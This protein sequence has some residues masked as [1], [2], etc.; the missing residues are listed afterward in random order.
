MGHRKSTGSC[1]CLTIAALAAF[2]FSLP[3]G[4]VPRLNWADLDAPE[5]RVY[6]SE[7]EAKYPINAFFFEREKWEGHAS[8]HV[9]WFIRGTDYPRYESSTVFPF[10][11][12]L[13]SKVD[14][15]ERSVYFPFF[16]Q[17]TDGGE[18]TTL[19]PLTLFAEDQNSWWNFYGWLFVRY[20]SPDNSSRGTALFPFFFHDVTP[21]RTA[22]TI[23]ALM[24]YEQRPESSTLI[25]PVFYSNAGRDETFTISPA[26]IYARDE[27]ET[28]WGFPVLPFLLFHSSSAEHNRWNFFSLFDYS[29]YQDGSF[30]FFAIP[31]F[32][33][34][35]DFLVIP[36][37]YFDFSDENRTLRFGPGYYWDTT[38]GQKD[39]IVGPFLWSE[40]SGGSTFHV[41]PVLYNSWNSEGAVSFSPLHSYQRSG[42]GDDAL[43]SWGFPILPILTYHSVS[44]KSAHRNFLSIVDLSFEEGRLDRLWVLPV[45]FKGSDYLLVPPVFFDLSSETE[46]TRFG[47]GYY[48]NTTES[49]KE[50][51]VGPVW[52][53]SNAVTSRFHIFPV[54]Y[55]RFSEDETFSVS[56]LHFY[57]REESESSFGIPVIPF[58]LYFSKE[59][60][61]THR[62]FLT[63]VDLEWNDDRL[64]R[65]WILPF[66]FHGREESSS[67]TLVL[68]AYYST[69]TDQES[70]S[71]SP[72]HFRS[73]SGES[74]ATG[75]PVFPFLFYRSQEGDAVH[76]SI[77]TLFDITYRGEDME[78]F[79]ALPFVFKGQDYFALAPLYFDFS[80]PEESLRFGPGYY[81]NRTN[82]YARSYTLLHRYARDGE[83]KDAAVSFGAPFIPFL[84]YHSW[85]GIE[86]RH[87]FLTIFDLHWTQDRLDRVWLFPILMK[88]E[89][90]LHVLPVYI[91]WSEKEGETERSR[92]INPLFVKWNEHSSAENTSRF[93]H[94]FW[95]PIVP[96]YFRKETEN[97]SLSVAGPVV[98]RTGELRDLTSLWVIPFAFWRGGKDGYTAAPPFYFRNGPYDAE[99]GRSF[100]LFHYHSWSRSH[101]RV[102]ALLYYHSYTDTA[103]EVV[104]PAYWSWNTKESQGN[105]LLPVAFNY[106]DASKSMHINITG[107]SKSRQAGIVGTSV[108][109]KQGRW[110][111]DTEF[112]WLYDAFS[113]SIRVSMPAALSEKQKEPDLEV[114]AK[115]EFERIGERVEKEEAESEQPRLA[116]S[117]LLSREDA[118]NFWSLRILYG[119]VAYQHADTRRHFRVLPFYWLSWD[120]KTDDRVYFIPAAFLS[121]S[122]EETEYFALIP[123]F[124]PVYGKQRS[125]K[126]FVESYGAIL[127]LREHDEEE[128]RDELSVLWPLANFYDSPAK[129]GSRILPFY[130]HR[131]EETDGVRVTTSVS[132]AHFYRSTESEGAGKSLLLA[133]LVPLYFQSR[134]R[135]ESGTDLWRGL[136]PFF[137][138]HDSPAKSELFALP[139]VYVQS[140]E[141]SSYINVL[142]G[143]FTRTKEPDLQETSALFSLFRSSTTP[144]ESSTLAAPFYYKR[145]TAGQPE[146]TNV[147]L[148]SYWH[149]DAEGILDFTV[150]PVFHWSAQRSFSSCDGRGGVV[151]LPLVYYRYAPCADPGQSEFTVASPLFARW[152]FNDRTRW[153]WTLPLVYR[154]TSGE[155]SFTN[156]MA[157]T[158]W[159]SREGRIQDFTVLPLFHWSADLFVSPLYAR[160]KDGEN[161]SSLVTLP[162]VYRASSG[163][164]N[165]TN[166]MLLSYWNSD[167]RGLRDL[168]VLPLFHWSSHRASN[169]CEG[170]GAL[171]FSALHYYRSSSCSG[172]GMTFVSPLFSR[173]DREEAETW[174]TTLP[175]IY[176]TSSGTAS[177]TNFMG[178]SY[179]NRNEGSLADITILPVFHLRNGPLKVFYLFPLYR[180]QDEY[181]TYFHLIPLVWSVSNEERWSAFAAGLYL[182][183]SAES[184]RQN[185]LYLLDHER[186]GESHSFNLAFSA[187]TFDWRRSGVSFSLLYGLGARASFTSDT[188]A[189]YLLWLGSWQNSDREFHT[190]LLPLYYYTSTESEKSLY[191]PLFLY[192]RSPDRTKFL[193]LP[194]YYYRSE[195]EL[196]LVTVPLFYYNRTAEKRMFVSLPWVDIEEGGNLFQLGLLGSAYYR[197]YNAAERSDRRMALMGVLY[198]EVQRP[199]R[200]Y[201]ARGSLWGLLWDYETEDTGFRKL[202][203]LKFLY[204]R[205]EID[206]TVRQRI[207]GISI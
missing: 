23:P 107:F 85:D 91:S 206:G 105:L 192:E 82:S 70:F 114:F 5:S 131:S 169:S 113:T 118:Y 160:W 36:P 201:R 2:F 106:T 30:R 161:E 8:F 195:S 198:N 137:L 190:R 48:W 49:S 148:L 87:N 138:Y 103:Y 37:A 129:S 24:R 182:R 83:G 196:S 41:F 77:A 185:L 88:G 165:F 154:S 59:G 95:A 167:E 176:H 56:P 207:F 117:I 173:W 21:E 72:V 71:I 84:T 64:S 1:C 187:V 164:S 22:W 10:Y 74:S 178:L 9:F 54:L 123:M 98:W 127:V 156:F 75:L 102:W 97:E 32:L 26:H 28:Y 86:T 135:D 81:Y 108:G 78:H 111:L 200:G 188:S 204:S 65:L 7:K 57:D 149:S 18:R 51:L 162:F 186:N 180:S 79:W 155:D 119:L 99:E 115:P 112:S 50:R 16:F 66:L 142:F 199:E 133:P 67:Y 94:M 43:V 39:R 52:W 189:D 44:Q 35:R 6:G 31:F 134:T 46:T 116:K 152:K 174:L 60:S 13:K 128:K 168:S 47:P 101:D 126:N 170:S 53:S 11:H 140:K 73:V 191:T 121:Y 145:R 141:N 3:A 100:G 139:G 109:E 17:Q 80:S 4:A 197:N 203:V 12:H 124:I 205:T 19:T 157:L 15:R 61:V 172:E 144:N 62:N 171:S 93:E 90:Y 34:G 42:E 122:A 132:F 40:G 33:K 68:P 183:S 14:N 96:L 184:S 130:W 158:F 125:G 27:S 89:G 120:E 166:F 20:G 177:F 181:E 63:V 92:T 45:F 202:S 29:S 159:N 193:S 58:A 136:I 194:F 25:T 175:F 38:A 153:V 146:L 55:N 110:Y 143:L 147:M 151:Y 163:E 150:F 76:L 179:W 69:E 104:F